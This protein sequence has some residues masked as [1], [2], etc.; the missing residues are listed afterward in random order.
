VDFRRLLLIAAGIAIIVFGLAQVT[1]GLNM[2]FG[3]EG[4][5][6]I[7]SAAAK[8]RA[9]ADAFASLARDATTTGSAPRQTDPSAKPLLDAV[10]DVSATAGRPLGRGDLTALADWSAAGG[11]A[12]RLVDMN[13]DT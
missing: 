9:S 13:T 6:V 12:G 10:F 1:G 5:P 7:T 3:P 2:L 11:K 8:A 4:D